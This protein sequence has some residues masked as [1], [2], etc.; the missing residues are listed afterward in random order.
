[1]AN[2][3]RQNPPV[4]AAGITAVIMGLVAAFGSLPD[5]QFA[6]IG[7]AVSLIAAFVSQRFTAPTT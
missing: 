2:P 6:A 4:T 7:A 3:A 5:D 1:M